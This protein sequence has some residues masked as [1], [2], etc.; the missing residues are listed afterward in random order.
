VGV[1]L[2]NLANADLGK[3]AI[4][5]VDAATIVLGSP[6]VLGG[7]HPL[8]ANAAYVANLLKPRARFGAIV[9]SYGWGGKMVNQLTGLMPNL[10]LELFEPVIVKG[11]P[12]PADLETLDRLA[13]AIAAKH[14][15]LGS[16]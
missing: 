16:A 12:K 9:G 14:A 8:V 11:L 2:F 4:A 7:A 15:G 10:K 13:E 6:T 1:D 3:I 5:L